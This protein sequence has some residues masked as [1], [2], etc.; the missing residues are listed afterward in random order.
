M[1]PGIWC[2]RKERGECLRLRYLI[3]IRDRSQSAIGSRQS[4]IT[5]RQFRDISRGVASCHRAVYQPLHFAPLR[6]RDFFASKR[7]IY[8]N[9]GLRVFHISISELAYKM[10]WVFSFSV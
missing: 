4:A 8:P 5:H 7:T 2:L 1:V 3:L 6:K 9:G 10:S